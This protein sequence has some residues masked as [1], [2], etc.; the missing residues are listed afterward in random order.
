[1]GAEHH[2]Q[3]QDTGHSSRVPRVSAEALRHGNTGA[4]DMR[5]SSVSP[6]GMVMRSK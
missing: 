6:M 1:M 2:R 5:K 4:M 3:R